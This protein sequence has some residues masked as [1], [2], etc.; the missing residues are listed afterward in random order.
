MRREYGDYLHLAKGVERLIGAHSRILDPE[1]RA[2]K[3]SRKRRMIGVDFASTP[4]PLAM[5]GFSQI[6]KLEINRKRL[7]Y[8]VGFS[9]FK[10][11]HNL[12]CFLHFLVKYVR[13]SGGITARFNQQAPELFD[14]FEQRFAGLLDQDPSEENAQRANVTPQRML[15]GAV[16]GA[17]GQLQQP[18][19]LIT[20]SPQG[21]GHGFVH[22]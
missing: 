5:I 12:L 15:F 3:R 6:G 4:P 18:R 2:A 17:G 7:G 11:A 21:L 8:S 10:L 20:G 16:L 9:H 13:S 22:S 1:K 14:S 19:T